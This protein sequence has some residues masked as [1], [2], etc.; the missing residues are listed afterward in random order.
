MARRFSSRA[1]TLVELLVVISIIGILVAL[2]LPAVQAAREAARRSQCKNNLKQIG[3]AFLN[4]ESAQGHFAPSGW[5][6]QWTGDPD[7]GTDERQPGGW[8]FTLLPYLE[9]G[10]A[11]V[12]GAGMPAAQKRAALT[13]QK[14]H[15]ATAFYCP[16]RRPALPTY[17]PESTFNAGIPDGGLVA[18]TDYGAS[19]G[20]YYEF[21]TGPPLNCMDNYPNCNWGPYSREKVDRFFN[22]AVLPRFPVEQRQITDGTSKT[23]LVAEKFVPPR[24]YG[25]TDGA[26][27]SNSCSD[28]NTL[29]QGYDWDVLRWTNRED[30]YQPLADTDRVNG[31]L[32]PACQLR[33]GS[34]HAGGLNA[35]YCDGSVHTI[36]YAVDPIVWEYLGVRNDGEVTNLD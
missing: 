9:E 33:F 35:V 18:K 10:S 20:S 23:L 28:N 25:D 13:E 21:S 12:L 22:G 32:V 30:R 14:A 8:A 2:L 29:Y 4:L 24:Y 15:V 31:A 17:G 16:S 27:T 19:G 7:M 1:F 3:L 26:Y 36:E 6:Y 11:Y 34:A 5:G